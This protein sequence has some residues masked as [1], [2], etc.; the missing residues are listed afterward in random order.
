[1]IIDLFESRSEKAVGELADK[2]GRLCSRV[3]VNI[4]KNERDA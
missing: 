2:Y 4:L 3:A 1:M